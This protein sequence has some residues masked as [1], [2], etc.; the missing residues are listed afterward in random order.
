M[1]D[2]LIVG[3]GIHGT[4]LSLYL[5]QRGSVP[6]DRL[7]VLD[8]YEA[9]LARWDATIAN[10]GMDYLRSSHA[11]NLHYDPFSLATFARTRQGAP[12]ARF[13]DPY[14]RPSV[15]LFRAHC[16]HLIE[17]Y[18]LD[19]LRIVGRANGLTRMEGGWRVETDN[20]SLEARRVIL[21]ISLTEQPYW[22]PWAQTLRAAGAP[23]HHIF[24]PQFRR[25]ALAGWKH[26]VVIGGGITA[27]QTALTLS[28]QAPVTLLM[29]H[30]TRIHAFDADPC[31]VTA[32]C[33]RSFHDEPDY[34]RRRA[35][36]QQA[37]H[38]GSMPPDVARDLQQT[39]LAGAL[40]RRLSEVTHA[41]L[42]QPLSPP[43]YEVE[44]GAGGEDDLSSLQTTSLFPS[45]PE[46]QAMRIHLHL[47]DNSTLEADLVILA[48]GFEAARPGGAWL[49]RAIAGY[50]LP[51]APC[52]YPVVDKSLRWQR[53][54]YV[55]GPLAELEIGPVARNIIGARLASERIARRA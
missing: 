5:T 44:R 31:W 18:N 34:T 47:A 28:A 51:V 23:I 4:H 22:P 32:L 24:D 43:L 33:L 27:A 7:C 8:P 29:R 6:Y 20:G 30:P 35:L 46:G 3:G 16:Q 50:G 1:L 49:D 15:E 45:L 10:V 42:A 25:E 40:T 12:L 26:A 54:L 19:S 48:T 36:I 11:H 21:A 17:R 13:T 52:G 55:T 9:P 53:G 14:G 39:A 41:C 38:R 37:R 2:Y